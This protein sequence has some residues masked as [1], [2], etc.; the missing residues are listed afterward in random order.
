MNFGQA[1]SRPVAINGAQQQQ[2]AFAFGAANLGGAA[3]RFF[4]GSS[5]VSFFCGR[6]GGMGA[7][8]VHLKRAFALQLRG[9]SLGARRP[10]R[11]K[12][13][14]SIVGGGSRSPRN[15]HPL[16]V[17]RARPTVYPHTAPSLPAQNSPHP[18]QNK[19][20]P[21][22]TLPNRFAPPPTS[23]FV[24]ADGDNDNMFD[25]ELPPT[26]A[27][28]APRPGGAAAAARDLSIEAAIIDVDEI[29]NPRA[30]ADPLRGL[31]RAVGAHRRAAAAAAPGDAGV[32]A[33]AAA[34]AELL[35]GTGARVIVR[36]PAAPAKPTAATGAA[37]AKTAAAPRAA[38]PAAAFVLRGRFIVVQGPAVGAD[39]AGGAAEA[40]YVDPS[41][42]DVFRVAQPTP[43]Y[44]RLVEALPEVFVGA[45]ADLR[46]LVALA[47][48]QAARAHEACGL[49][50]PPWRRASALLARWGLA[51]RGGAR[52]GASGAAA[53][54]R[55]EDEVVT[56]PTS[57]LAR[58]GSRE[59]ADLA[60]ATVREAARGAFARLAAA[61]GHAA[62]AAAAR[63][64]AAARAPARV[65]RGFE[66]PP[67]AAAALAA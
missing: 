59:A 20:L 48:A 61:T 24:D 58:L 60:H 45:A 5:A 55:F 30:E 52:D 12:A 36:A 10:Q 18:P 13:E 39:P 40:V 17:L 42:R 33:L 46:R 66:L 50:L 41:F 49:P 31:R 3:G 11:T 32:D 38:S 29:A 15:H 44:A 63:P 21:N 56:P 27:A 25:L 35:D 57:P 53:A 1:S 28:A 16:F 62:G 8:A 26:S 43:G 67:V 51:P 64:P 4:P 14:P 54:A 19:P 22:K 47:A 9:M 6:G 7:A 2:G 37:A 65:G 34:L 23:A